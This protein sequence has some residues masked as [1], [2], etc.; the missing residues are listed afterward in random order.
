[1]KCS[2]C[3]KEVPDKAKVCGYCGT[4]LEKKHKH[5]CPDCR[6]GVPAKAKVCGF[7]GAKLAQPAA[8]TPKP[9]PK[10]AAPETAVPAKKAPV[11]KVEVKTRKLPKWA[12]PAG[13]GAAALILVVVLFAGRSPSQSAQP[14]QSEA[15]H[16]ESSPFAPAQGNWAAI[17]HDE[18]AMT[19]KISQNPDGSYDV[20]L[21][22]EGASICG[23]DSTGESLLSYS[24]QGTGTAQGYVLDVHE[25]GQCAETE[26]EITYDFQITFDPETDTL[27]DTEETTWHRD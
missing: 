23:Y 15:V 25:V 22:D 5:T 4:K 3:G 7:C 17:D 2:R 14:S 21:F 24:S 1:M 9:A 11:K 16:T 19:L 10:K 6:K 12:L 20:V 27:L 8:E 13:L 18:S 26:E